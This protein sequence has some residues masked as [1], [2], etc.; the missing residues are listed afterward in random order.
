MN[1]APGRC[2]E[3]RGE[4]PFVRPELIGGGEQGFFRLANRELIRA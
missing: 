4:A 2:A 3:S 1:R